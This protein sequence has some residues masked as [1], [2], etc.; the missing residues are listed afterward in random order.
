PTPRIARRLLPSLA[1]PGRRGGRGARGGSAREIGALGATCRPN[2][3]GA[4][5]ARSR[6]PRPNAPGGAAER[7]G[8]CRARGVSRLPA[9]SAA[10]TGW[11]DIPRTQQGAGGLDPVE[12]RGRRRAAPPPPSAAGAPRSAP[13]TLTESDRRLLGDLFAIVEEHAEASLVEID[14]TRVE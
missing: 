13:D 11:T 3:Q 7:L 1:R 10:T 12:S 9:L 8:P 14:R 2:A 6:R 5:R 4:H